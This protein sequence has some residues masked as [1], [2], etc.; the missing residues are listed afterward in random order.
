MLTSV[1]G[2]YPVWVP[3]NVLVEKDCLCRQL[4]DF[5]RRANSRHS[6]FTAIEN[7]IEFAFVIRKLFHFRLIRGLVRRLWCGR[8]D[9]TKGRRISMPRTLVDRFDGHASIDFRLEAR[10]RAIDGIGPHSTQIRMT[11][12][13][14][15]RSCTTGLLSDRDSLSDDCETE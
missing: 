6:G 9:A 3:G 5:S 11:R 12:A 15:F 13:G 7:R 10:W 2:D 14:T 4:N 1:G 8:Q